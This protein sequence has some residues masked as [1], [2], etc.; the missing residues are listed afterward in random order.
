V[1]EFAALFHQPTQ[2]GVEVNLER[3]VNVWTG[4][5]L[6]QAGSTRKLVLL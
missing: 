3:P 2:A 1:S 6:C 5:E 4:T